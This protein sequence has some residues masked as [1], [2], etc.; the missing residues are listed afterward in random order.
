MGCGCRGGRKN[1]STDLS[2]FGF[3]K[4]NQLK[5]LEEQKK[6]EAEKAKENK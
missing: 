4:P 6:A 5:I 2:R 3:L 1:K